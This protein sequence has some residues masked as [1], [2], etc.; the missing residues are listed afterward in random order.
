MYD[1]HIKGGIV[2]NPE[3]IFRAD[4]Y[5]KNQKIA[6]ISDGEESFKSKKIIDATGNYVMP[7]FIDPHSHLNDPGATESE[8]FYT[9]TCSAAA[10]GIST[11]MEHP[12]TFPLPSS[13]KAFIEKKKIAAQKCVVDFCLFGA[14]IP[15]NYRDVDDMAEE[16]AI[17][18]KA[19]MPYSVEIPQIDDGQLLSHL[20][21]LRNTGIVL[22]VHCENDSI[23]RN[24]VA[25]MASNEKLTYSD[26]PT[27]RPEIAEIEAINRLSMFTQATGGKAHVAHCSTAAGIEIVSKHKAQQVDITVE[28]C[29]HYLYFNVN[30]IKEL[31]AF[32]ICNPPFRGE[33]EVEKIWRL[34]EQEKVDFIGTDHAPYTIEEKEA[35]IHNVFDT[36][37]GF[38]GIQTCFP[39]FYDQAVNKRN[40]DPRLF[41]R[42]SS[43]NAAKRYGIFPQ[44]GIIAP[45]SDGDLVI[46]DP[47][48]K[49]KVT[50]DILF[51]KIKKTPFMDMT[52]QGKVLMT[53]VRGTVVYDGKEIVVQPGYG[54]FVR[55]CMQ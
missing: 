6:Q 34:I 31:G 18:F 51:Y 1:L 17:A 14:C 21:N 45:G 41:V 48:K 46:F 33:E 37:A 35:E 39:F 4:V 7:G 10:G 44:K 26:Y 32:G 27:S 38:S 53:I 24:L 55:R 36:P 12:L 2:V 8:D 42:M 54:C 20:Q 25:A 23:I 15:D 49:H 29:A 9:G 47:H 43:T 16:G 5:I 3:H 50:P 40:L 11:V 13:P 28:T 22:T 52:I 30:N 19:Y